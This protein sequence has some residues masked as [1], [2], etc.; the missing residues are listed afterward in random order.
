MSTRKRFDLSNLAWRGLSHHR[1]AY[2]A[3]VL[4]AATATAIICGAFFVG[5]SVRGS[6]EARVLD[7]LGRIDQL[8]ETTGWVRRELATEL[9]SDPSNESNER[10]TGGV[11]AVPL[12][13][14]RATVIHADS[15][16]RSNTVTIYGVPA[17][18]WSLWPHG[19]RNETEFADLGRRRHGW[20]NAELADAV[21]AKA[22]ESVLVHLEKPSDIAAEHPLGE[23]T[24][25]LRPLRLKVR[26]LVP[27][28]GA[29]LFRLDQGQ[30]PVHNLYVPLEM[31]GR[32]LER[33]TEANAIVV[34]AGELSPEATTT[35]LHTAWHLE[36]AGLRFE[37]DGERGYARLE[38][39][40][41]LLSPAVL[42][43]ASK[44]AFDLDG[45]TLES[46][47]YL[48]NTMRVGEREIP[49]STV[50]ALGVWESQSGAVAPALA[51]LAPGA[52][53]TDTINT[54][55]PP[56]SIVL[57]DWAAED[58]QAQIGDTVRL[59]YYV[60]DEQHQLTDADVDFRLSS[61]VALSGDAADPHWTPTFPG[62]SDADTLQSWDP[63][64]PVDLSRV[65]DKDD[66]YWEEHRTTPKA[67]VALA[68]GKELWASRFGVATSL[69][70][71][72]MPQ[73][74][75][76]KDGDGD[77]AESDDSQRLDS[78]AAKFKSTLL[79]ELSPSQVGLSVQ[80]IRAM[81]L[82]SARGATDF[83]L[84]FVSFSFLLIVAAVV[85]L[86]LVFRLACELRFAEFG[87][88]MAVGFER[89]KVQ[90]LLLRE[91]L[92][93]LVFGALLG[94]VAGVAYASVLVTGLKTLWQGAVN[95]PFLQLHVRPLSVLAGAGIT[96]VLS[97][98]MIWLVARRASRLAPARLLAGDTTD[99][100]DGQRRATRF[101]A[102]WQWFV[103]LALGVGAAALVIY[104]AAVT[105]SRPEAIFFTAGAMSL[106]S[107]LLTFWIL[108]RGRKDSVLP[109]RGRAAL[110]LLAARNAGR[111]PG[112]S[113]LTVTVLAAAA[114]LVVAVA[115]QRRD[116]SQSTPDPA[117]GDG[118]YALMARSSVPLTQSLATDA[119]RESLQIGDE[120]RRLLD[121]ASGLH[122]FRVR[123]GDDASC[124]NLYRPQS[125]RILG[126]P[127]GFVAQGGFRWA[128]SLAESEAEK[129]NPWRLL[130]R[131]FPDGALAAVGD[132]NTVMWILHA[133]LGDTVE[134]VDDHGRTVKLRLVGLLSHSIFQSELV[135][136]AQAFVGAFPQLTGE[137]FFL[138]GSGQEDSPQLATAL[139]ADLSDWGF[140]VTSTGE[141]LAAFKRVE[142]TYLS[143]FQILGGLGLLL[144]TLGLA[145][146]LYRNV[147]ERRGEL[148]L[149]RAVGFASRSIAWLVFSETILLLGVGVVI[150]GGS[151]LL[152]VAPQ[153]A[154]AASEVD[155]LGLVV[156]L[157]VIL[158]SGLLAAVGALRAAL[159]A[160]LLPAL[161]AG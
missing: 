113:L 140:D 47:T 90:S 44:T 72:P 64:F 79:R 34:A 70:V 88:L 49:Y 114:F 61:V 132:L 26:R 86:T 109:G 158:A 107:G 121:A 28:E 25:R 27:N 103:A 81:G 123:P 68:S 106:A 29:G 82:E 105:V 23:R 17:R 84:L 139:E 53:K 33:E 96:C 12:I 104:G 149:L 110:F 39:R 19:E 15:Q 22:E 129:E 75:G 108:I 97:F 65:R 134:V 125:P 77:D 115:A 71:R 92:G 146:V 13:I 37:V 7:R 21:G 157:V 153:L 138:V 145:V 5:D 85:L 38:S 151:A 102:R 32:A 91:G 155:T 66:D 11:T 58:A 117:S 93:L 152:A 18:F 10:A 147:T 78:W 73:P 54:G 36:D 120:T 130:D 133:G 48:A 3:A 16:A 40:E 4:A 30:G 76:E 41:L 6:L 62:V 57:N 46:L 1:R 137:S 101:A 9:E 150:G 14:Q 43:A 126:A 35:R 124:L 83:T 143:T 122:A 52:L 136:S 135:I 59:T 156:T 148:A 111:S 127:A 60:V 161:R 100:G 20:L 128:Q 55:A 89:Q 112:R 119:G 87:T 74:E 51:A 69:R 118:G 154:S 99:P 144:G 31:L 45:L 142:N 80:P 63:S 42:E 67:F 141:Q 50:T 8:V 116:V 160:P 131:E 56:P 2:V 159:K 95:A 94:A 98:V 24:E